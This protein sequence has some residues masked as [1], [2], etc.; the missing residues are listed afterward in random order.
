MNY[1]KLIVPVSCVLGGSLLIVSGAWAQ[2]KQ[3]ATGAEV[4]SVVHTSPAGSAVPVATFA[5]VQP[6]PQP[7][8]VSQSGGNSV[9][10]PAPQAASSPAVVSVIVAT[11]S[12]EQPRPEA[13]VVVVLPEVANEHAKENQQ[14]SGIKGLML[15]G[16]TCPSVQVSGDGTVTNND[17]GPDR[18]AGTAGIYNALTNA[19]VTEVTA[20]E[21]GNFKLDLD[22]GTYY[23]STVFGDRIGMTSLPMTDLF[24]VV[25]GEYTEV[26]FMFDNGMR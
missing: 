22:P 19:L 10:R 2:N 12:P 20:N 16:P 11:P 5:A 4:S 17:C 21:S 7:V 6:S 13:S 24:T 1:R 25:E 15:I 18:Y 8:I 23:A 26:T 14:K 3:A 9:P